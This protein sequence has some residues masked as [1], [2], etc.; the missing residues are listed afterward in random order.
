MPITVLITGATGF[1][2][3]NL[4]ASLSADGCRVIALSRRARDARAM[5]GP[6]V[7]VIGDLREVTNDEAIDACVHLAGAR[8]LGLPWSAT[9]RQTLINSRTRITDAL[10]GL[11]SRLARPPRVL[12][13]A[14]AVGWYGRAD[15]DLAMPCDE[16]SACQPGQFQSNLCTVVERTA[17]H[18][19]ALGTR[20]ARMRFG[21]VLGIDGGAWPMQA[22]T[23]RLGLATILGS[24]HQYFPWVHI[25]DA[26]GLVRFAIANE[27]IGGPVNVVAPEVSTQAEFAEELAR[28]FGQR[29]RLRLPEA[30]VRLCL[31]EMADLL[32]DGRPVVPRVALTYG[33]E[34]AWPRLHRA[35]ADLADLADLAGRHAR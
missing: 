31:G 2:G 1:I 11:I 20:V 21:I 29:V 4:V 32:L 22:A 27:L 34:F 24:G 33:Y 26:V 8:V 23:A 6:H 15:G 10:L 35:L 14:S 12:V 25:A 30:P 28:S 3:R 17:M 9:R 7:R 19:E 16:S 5:L 18:A 13:S